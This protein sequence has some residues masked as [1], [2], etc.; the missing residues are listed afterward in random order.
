MR[1]VYCCVGARCVPPQRRT[2]GRVT[3]QARAAASAT[4]PWAPY[5]LGDVVALHDVECH[6]RHDRSER[7]RDTNDALSLEKRLHGLHVARAIVDQ[8]LARDHAATGRVL[9]AFD[10]RQR[11]TM[12]QV[13]RCDSEEGMKTQ[14]ERK[15]ERER[16]T[17]PPYGR[18]GVHHD[19][20][21]MFEG[22]NQRVHKMAL[23]CACV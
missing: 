2:K 8:I 16:D 9:V 1:D 23:L 22:Y 7:R 17:Y 21:V 18:A 10:R 15:R 14:R 12:G 4:A 3:A 6:H 5:Q 19:I 11:V 13:R 20:G